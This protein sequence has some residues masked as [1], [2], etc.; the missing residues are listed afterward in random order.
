AASQIS[1]TFEATTV[2]NVAFDSIALAETHGPTTLRSRVAIRRGN[3]YCFY[4]QWHLRQFKQAG[5]DRQYGVFIYNSCDGDHQVF[6]TPADTRFGSCD[7]DDS[8]YASALYSLCPILASHHVPA[9]LAPRECDALSLASTALDATLP[10]DTYDPRLPT[11]L[12]ATTHFDSTLAERL[13]DGTCLANLDWQ[14]TAWSMRWSDGATDARPGSGQ[15]GITDTHLLAPQPSATDSARSAEVT[16]VATLH[17]TGDAVDFD[18][19]GAPTV[20][21]RAADVQISNRGTA[22]ALD[23]AAIYTPPQLAVAAVPVGQL[24]DG[25]IPPPDPH[26][27]PLTHADT[28]RGRLLELFPRVLVV[29]PGT[30]T[31]A[32]TTLGTA[33]SEVVAWTYLGP[34]TDAPSREATPPNGTGAP[35]H[36]VAVQWNHA[37]R[38]DGQ[39]RP[40][41]EQVPLRLDVRT[42]YPD[43]HTEDE[44][45]SGSI[46]V[47]IWYVAL[48]EVG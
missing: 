45:V 19:A 46:R 3:R 4:S 34:A 24:G 30:E 40:V 20:V 16:A 39:R 31:L 10:P 37:Q 43:G 44:T 28:I 22:S 13:S 26:Q 1:A 8:R 18:A 21:H 2:G 32:G 33:R 7:N 25:T 38:L 47:T 12:T 29:Q 5:F 42:T 11:P 36:P 15:Q 9:G 35:D 17:L 23:A 48:M 41:D 6:P 27:P 14:D